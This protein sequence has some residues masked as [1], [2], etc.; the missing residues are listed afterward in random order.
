MLQSSKTPSSRHFPPQKTPKIINLLHFEN[1][2]RKNKHKF[3]TAKFSLIK[4]RMKITICEKFSFFL[5][6][7]QYLLCCFWLQ[8]F[9]WEMCSR[10]SISAALIKISGFLFKE[11]NC[12][13][14][15]FCE[16]R[17]WRFWVHFFDRI[18]FGFQWIFNFES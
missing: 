4:I 16:F 7:Q 1:K 5:F 11:K 6:F 12:S 9:H 15:V 13:K 2:I 3:F 17:K 8:N 18:Y 10:W 14:S